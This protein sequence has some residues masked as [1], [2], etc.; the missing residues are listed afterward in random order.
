MPK[1]GKESFYIKGMFRTFEMW[2]NRDKGF[3]FKDFPDEVFKLSTDYESFRGASTE[4]KLI[5]ST[6]T[7]IHQ[8]HENSKTQRKVIVVNLILGTD[9]LMNKTGHGQYQGLKNGISRDF[10]DKVQGAS[11]ER[12]TSRGMS[13]EYRVYWL[14]DKNG[15]KFHNVG[16]NDVV[17]SHVS[18]LTPEKCLYMDY[19]EERESFMIGVMSTF[20]QL[21]LKF[22]EFFSSEDLQ[23]KIDSSPNNKLLSHDTNT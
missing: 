17:L 13:F 2:Y 8:F 4:G 10:M 3:Y 1:I 12:M 18:S 15:L 23:L 21:A 14:I 9:Y 16:E 7:A 11:F 6:H 5:E 19:T 22:I 20:D